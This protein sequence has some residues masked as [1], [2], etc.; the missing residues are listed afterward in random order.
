M[1]SSVCG[2]LRYYTLWSYLQCTNE[3]AVS[4]PTH[5]YRLTCASNVWKKA[6]TSNFY[7]WLSQVPHD[8]H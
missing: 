8:T 1:L 5:A 2:Q 3:V 7:K 6:C 4:Q